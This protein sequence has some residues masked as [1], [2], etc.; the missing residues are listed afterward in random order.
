MKF[1]LVL[2]VSA[3]HAHLSR[4]DMDILFGEGS[5][6]HVKKPI[7]QPGQYASEEQI[8]METAKGQTKLRVIGPLRPDTQIELSFT[9]A[10]K[11]GIEAPVRNSGDIAGSAGAKLIGPAGSLDL[12]EGI[13][14]SA[15]HVHLYP[16]TA[17]KYGLVDG[18]IVDVVAG[19]GTRKTTLHG[20]LVRAGVKH[21]DEVH[22]DTDEA[23]ACNAKTGE[24]VDIIF[25]KD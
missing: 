16:E 17:A 5:E 13:I 1:Q 7:G 9:D 10:M 2:G 22:I 6:L 14:I 3:R 11:A 23:N 25:N 4:K 21:A 12:K 20:C 19:S 8:I 15:R 24:M 18:D